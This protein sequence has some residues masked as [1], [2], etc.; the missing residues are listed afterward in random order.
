MS[1]PYATLEES[2]KELKREMER[3]QI[4]SVFKKA[5]VLV[6]NEK[7][8]PTA[9]FEILLDGVQNSGNMMS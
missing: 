3:R 5:K 4:I 7:Y 9:T 1:Q 6:V 2:V 8:L